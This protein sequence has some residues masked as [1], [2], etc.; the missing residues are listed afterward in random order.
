M[1]RSEVGLINLDP[2]IGAEI[3]KTRPA[4]IVNDDA[5]GVLPLRVIVPL[6]DWKQ[7]YATA[8]WLVFVAP[9]KFNGLA[10]D[11]AADTFQVRSVSQQRFV[12]RLGRLTDQQMSAVTQA[13]ALVLVIK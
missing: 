8:P 2:T 11:S 13:L 7:D 3:K 1:R 9:D 4:I 5:I 10:K 6:T 12:R